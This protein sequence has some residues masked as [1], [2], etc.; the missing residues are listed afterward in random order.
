MASRS[1]FFQAE[2]GIRDV[3]VTGVQ[4]CALPISDDGC[5]DRGLEDAAGNRDDAEHRQRQRDA[6]GDGEGGDDLEKGEEPA[7]PQQERQ[8]EEQVIVARQDVLDTKSEERRPLRRLPPD[9]DGG[10]GRVRQEDGFAR[11]TWNL[12]PRDGPVVLAE[13][14]E[15]LVTNLQP[16]RRRR[17]LEGQLEGDAA[18]AEPRAL[19]LRAAGPARD[20]AGSHGDPAAELG[21]DALH[22]G[23]P[24]RAFMTA[25]HCSPTKFGRSRISAW[26][27]T[28]AYWASPCALSAPNSISKGAAAGERTD[29]EKRGGARPNSDDGVPA[30]SSG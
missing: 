14:L 12:D 10:L 8:Q 1:F 21:G 15:P 3:A 26:P 19:D 4:T 6:V 13:Q 11:G 9:L 22:R 23:Q 25:S 5:G 30:T 18:V 29:T 24:H 20:L 2:D 27:A 17:A 16:R 28:R 7:A